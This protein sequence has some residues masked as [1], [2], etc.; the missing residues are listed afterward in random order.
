MRSSLFILI[1]IPVI[2]IFAGCSKIGK[3]NDPGAAAHLCNI[4][5]FTTIY[6]GSPATYNIL[7]DAKGNPTEIK[8][9]NSSTGYITRFFY[10]KKGN[11]ITFRLDNFRSPTDSTDIYEHHYYYAPNG[12]F[13]NDTSYL[14]PN[15][16]VPPGYVPG[17]N[18]LELDA[19]GRVIKDSALPVS[20]D[21]NVIEVVLDYTYDAKGDLTSVIDEAGYFPPIHYTSYDDKVNWRQTN[22]TWQ[23]INR[24]YSRNNYVDP[25]GSFS[26]TGYTSFGLPRG[27]SFQPVPDNTNVG[28]FLPSSPYVYNDLYFQYACDLPGGPGKY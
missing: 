5:Q 1:A 28:I 21:P 7:Y 10:D 11:L 15:F 16:P 24:D 22:R 9:S 8:P 25:A 26:I 12:K 6:S 23:L 14:L 4:T 18:K 2:G 13:I 20:L 17:W 19:E 3:F 27:I